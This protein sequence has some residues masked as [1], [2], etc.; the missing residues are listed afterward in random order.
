M[1]RRKEQFLVGGFLSP[2]AMR[3]LRFIRDYRARHGFAPTRPEMKR[4]LGAVTSRVRALIEWGY[5]NEAPHRARAITLTPAGVAA[6]EAS[7][8]RMRRPLDAAG[9]VDHC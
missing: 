4:E 1:G 7:E 9:E 3:V 2:R 8:D 5:L 6:V